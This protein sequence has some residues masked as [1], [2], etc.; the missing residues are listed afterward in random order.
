MQNKKLENLI[1]QDKLINFIIKMYNQRNN[2]IN[3][4]TLIINYNKKMIKNISL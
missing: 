2:S 1:T 4:L 3:K